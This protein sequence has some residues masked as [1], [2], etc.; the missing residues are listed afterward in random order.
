MMV[1]GLKL[2]QDTCTDVLVRVPIGVKRHHDQGNSYKGRCSIRAGLQ[3][4]S[5]LTFHRGKKQNNKAKQNKT[6]KQKKKKLP[7]VVLGLLL[8][9]RSITKAT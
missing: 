2:N 7:A 5:I 1:M 9:S 6:N 8:L 4:Q 3:V